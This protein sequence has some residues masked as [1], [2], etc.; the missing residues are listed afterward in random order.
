MNTSDMRRKERNNINKTQINANKIEMDYAAH[1][2][3]IKPRVP[4]SEAEII[5]S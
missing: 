3:V 1:K 5:P 2:E 4:N